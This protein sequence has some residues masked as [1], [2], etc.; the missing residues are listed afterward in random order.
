M[1]RAEKLRRVAPGLPDD[2]LALLASKPPAEVDLIVAALRQARR[3]E[4]EH[5]A[6]GKRENKRTRKY[7]TLDKARWATVALRALAEPGGGP[8]IPPDQ[9]KRDLG[10]LRFLQE[11]VDMAPV[12][13][14]G[15]A[16][17]L[18]AQ[19]ISWGEIGQALGVTRQTAWERFGRQAAPDKAER[20]S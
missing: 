3:D 7:D 1:N 14:A 2:Q 10:A 18:H 4:R 5:L 11:Q 8:D 13:L 15:F 19:G 16:R 20:A 9:R 17:G 6:A 12:V